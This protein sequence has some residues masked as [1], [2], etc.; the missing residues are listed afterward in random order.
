L[1]NNEIKQ[2]ISLTELI[3]AVY[4]GK[5][6]IV[7][8]SICFVLLSIAI[9]LYL[10]NQY[11]ST[12]TLIINTESSSKLASLAGSLGGLAGAAGINLG[13]GQE[14]SN[15]LIAKQL[16]TS[17]AF[18]LKFIEK[19]QI[20]VPIMAATSWDATS[21]ELLIDESK[22][23]KAKNVWLIGDNPNSLTRPKRENTVKAFKDIIKLSEDKKTGVLTFSAEFYSPMLAQQW[24]QLFIKEINETIRQYDVDQ[25]NK[26][27]NYLTDLVQTTKNTHFSQTFNSLIE[28]QT[29]KLMLSKV[30]LDYVF[31]TI[32]PPNLPEKKS[33][34]SRALICIF[35]SFLGFL[36][37]CFFVLIRYFIKQ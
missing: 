27:I 28:E 18:I 31:K 11:K 15:P 23:D 16:V 7:I 5:L 3:Q 24:L 35:G 32:D 14:D 6:I 19:H 17:K 22:Y 8:G 20:L 30:R 9:A 37:M 34:P 33:K 29:K 12:A 25:A 36:S 13:T 21:N 26:S 10:P 4:Q 2:D 1:P